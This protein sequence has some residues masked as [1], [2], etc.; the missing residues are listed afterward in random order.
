MS[1]K[2]GGVAVSDGF[3]PAPAAASIPAVAVHVAATVPSDAGAVGVLV[4]PDGA[5]PSEVGHDRAALTAAGFE[6]KRGQVLVLPAADGPP[7]VLAGTGPSVDADGLRDAAGAFARSAGARAHLA[8]VVPSIDGV[9]ADRAGQ[10]VTEGVLLARYRYDVLQTKTKESGLDAVTLI[11]ADELAAGVERGRALA[12]ACGIARDLANCPP[13]HL[14]AVAM[15]DVAQ[16]LGG[17]AGLGVEVFDEP[18]LWK[19]GCGGL[20]GVNAGSHDEPAHDQAHLPTRERRPTGHLTLVGKG[21]MYDSGG[22]SLKPADGTHATM[23]NDMSGAGAVLAAMSALPAIGCRTGGHRLPDVHRQHAVGHRAEAGRRDHH[24]RRHDRGGH[25]HRCRGSARHGRRPRA[26][27]RGAHRRHRR[28][29]DPHR[30]RACAPSGPRSPAVMGNDDRPRR[31][32]QG[33]VRRRPTSRCGSCRSPGATASTSTPTI[34]DIKNL[35][36]L[37][38]RR[39]HRRAVPRRVRRRPPVGPHRHRRHRPE[40]TRRTPGDPPVARA[41]APGSSCSWPTRLRGAGSMTAVSPDPAAGPKSAGG[42]Q[43]ILDTIERVGNKVPHPAIIFI[44]LCVLVIVLS[45]V[46]AVFDVSVTYEVAEQPPIVAEEEY[47]GGS[48]APEIVLPEGEHA[49][50]TTSR[51]SRRPPRSR[52]CSAATAS[53]S[54]SPRSS[55]TSPASPSCRSCSSP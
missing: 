23:K 32:D 20:L 21:I 1:V 3:D 18:A 54:S 5:V 42:L 49:S 51:S 19:L 33:G 39:H 46:L 53:A 35:G 15:A 28:H 29:R 55:A 31:P 2:T 17:A 6:G 22:I 16:R 24:P 13:A 25:Q 4:G 40:P 50:T 12:A 26:R 41:S 8:I 11:G 52:A 10:V 14:T 37:Q 7:L 48:V 34:A 47:L 9:A 27:H 44:G 45:A 36:G 38:R 30:R 43:R